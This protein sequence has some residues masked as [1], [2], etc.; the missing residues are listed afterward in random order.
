[1]SEEFSNTNWSEGRFVRKR[2]KSLPPIEVDCSDWM[3][4]IPAENWSTGQ[5]KRD[6]QALPPAEVSFHA[7][8]LAALEIA[9]TMEPNLKPERAFL[10]AAR[11]IAALDNAV[12]EAG[13]TYD[14]KRSRIDEAG[15]IIVLNVNC[16]SDAASSVEYFS[17]LVRETLRDQPDATLS[18][19]HFAR[20]A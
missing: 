14:A 3:S 13:V 15:V 17:N 18:A 11:L 1:M 2:G 10:L 6:C 5:F 12:P 7:S 19:I 16:P 4:E 20:A 9:L 8:P